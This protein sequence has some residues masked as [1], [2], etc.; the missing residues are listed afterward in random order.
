MVDKIKITPRGASRPLGV[1]QK[2]EKENE[3]NEVDSCLESSRK[4]RS[5]FTS[6]MILVDKQ[7]HKTCSKP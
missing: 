7:K 6:S 2:R 5:P 4:A 3:S 1:I